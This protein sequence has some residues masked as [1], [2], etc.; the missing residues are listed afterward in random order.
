MFHT[1]LTHNIA[2]KQYHNNRLHV[3]HHRSRPLRCRYS[4][5]TTPR[6]GENDDAIRITAWEDYQATDLIRLANDGEEEG[7]EE[8]EKYYFEIVEKI[9]NSGD[10]SF[11]G[12]ID[13]IEYQLNV[14]KTAKEARLHTRGGGGGGGREGN[15]SSSSVPEE[16]LAFCPEFESLHKELVTAGKYPVLEEIRH[17]QT[18]QVDWVKHEKI[19]DL[20]ALKTKASENPDFWSLGTTP[21]QPP[22]T[23]VERLTLNA[24]E[25]YALLAGNRPL[26]LIQLYAPF[27]EDGQ[28]QPIDCPFVKRALKELVTT[29]PQ[30]ISCVACRI[31]GSTALSAVFYP[32]ISPNRERAALLASFGAQGALVAQSPYYGVLIG[33][34]LGY[35]REN[36]YHHVKKT[37]N[38]RSG[39]SKAVLDQVVHDLRECSPVVPLQRWR[40]GYDDDDALKLVANGNP[41]K[42]SRKKKRLSSSVEALEAFL[43]K[44]K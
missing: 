18:I 25:I 14:S 20:T 7:E 16:L 23:A 35:T 30:I 21:S 36:I 3:R 10:V 17:K 12:Y 6:G 11:I 32:N 1:S 13:G 29:T 31:E 4:S 39:I 22:L 9:D 43:G 24:G 38:L 28:V 40:N 41:R 33:E 44:K 37:C 27:V 34:C 26:A 42:R 2:P 8:G 5:E 19:T 15:F